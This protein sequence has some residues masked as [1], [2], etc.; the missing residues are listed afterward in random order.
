[1]LNLLSECHHWPREGSA[2]EKNNKLAPPHVRVPRSHDATLWLQDNRLGSSSKSV[3]GGMSA[4]GQKQTYAVQNA[5]SA[6]PPIA[7]AKAKFCTK[8]CPLYPQKQ[9]CAV[10]WA[11][12]ALGQ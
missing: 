9:T 11:M 2:T 4:L 1:M 3:A 7:T 10:Q 12:S 5:M 8:S 6:L